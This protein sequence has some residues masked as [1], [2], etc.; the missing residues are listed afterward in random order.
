MFEVQLYRYSIIAQCSAFVPAPLVLPF[1]QFL[2]C[3]MTGLQFNNEAG[4]RYSLKI[5][6]SC[7]V[8]SPNWIMRILSNES[9]Q[10][11]SCEGRGTTASAPSA[12]PLNSPL[13][14]MLLACGWLVHISAGETIMCHAMCLNPPSTEDF[15]EDLLICFG[16]ASGGHI[17]CRFPCIG[18][19]IFFEFW[20]GVWYWSAK[21]DGLGTWL[22]DWL[23]DWLGDQLIWALRCWKRFYFEKQLDTLWN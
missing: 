2:P 10:D 20:D 15:C 9:F 21:N 18:L 13:S 1:S 7:G 3:V 12:A 8:A 4:N 11:P 14:H 5:W 16:G 23:I 6:C 22:I 19:V 17:W